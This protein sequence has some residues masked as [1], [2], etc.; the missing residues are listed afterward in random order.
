MSSVEANAQTEAPRT[1]SVDFKFEA[2]AIP[3]SDVDRAKAFYKKLGWREDAD[4]P[5]RDDFRVVQMT[6]PGSPA[7]VLF[8]TGITAA[9]PGSYEGLLLVVHDIDK[10]HDELVALGVDVSEVFHPS[11]WDRNG[12]RE[13]GKDPEDQSYRSWLSFEDPDGNGWLVQEIKTRL[14]GR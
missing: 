6:P 7:S 1:A 8:G 11:G 4:F 10:A 12:T 14:P 2:A 13:S 9:E 5:V 3:V